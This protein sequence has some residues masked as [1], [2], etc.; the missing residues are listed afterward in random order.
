LAGISRSDFI[1][2]T[3]PPE[4]PPRSLKYEME[5]VMLAEG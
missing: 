4:T 5:E 2:A 1:V 3:V